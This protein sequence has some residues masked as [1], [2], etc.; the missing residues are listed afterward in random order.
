MPPSLRQGR[1]LTHRN[2][3][4][5][6]GAQPALWARGC[7]TRDLSCGQ[8]GTLRRLKPRPSCFSAAAAAA[9]SLQSC[10][11]LC[12]PI[13]AAHQAPPSLGFSGQE[14]WSGLPLPSPVSVLPTAFS[15]LETKDPSERS[16]QLMYRV[17]GRAR[18]PG[19][20]QSPAFSFYWVLPS[21]WPSRVLP[22]RR[23]I[24]VTCVFLIGFTATWE[25]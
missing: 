1:F 25:R 15:A 24:W 17:P 7:F 6:V 18:R 20:V 11:T 13:D 5:V 12:D 10:P 23:R 3:W 8:S 14:H 9:K 19:R 4:H 21:K 2:A 16:R 22:N